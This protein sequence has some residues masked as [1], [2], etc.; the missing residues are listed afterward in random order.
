MATYPCESDQACISLYQG[1]SDRQEGSIPCLGNLG[2]GGG[3][4]AF[5]TQSPVASSK[6][7]Q[8]QRKT[9]LRQP[10]NLWPGEHGVGAG[11]CYS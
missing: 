9:A 2:S 5:Q 11:G 1:T 8:D 4:P 7:T 6:C 3:N 10:S